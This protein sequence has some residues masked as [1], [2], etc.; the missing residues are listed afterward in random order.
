[1]EVPVAVPLRVPVPPQSPSQQQEEEM[2]ISAAAS[3]PNPNPV[4]DL[5]RDFSPTRST[6]PSSV[7]LG[8]HNRSSEEAAERPSRPEHRS[9]MSFDAGV[10]RARRGSF[11]FLGGRDEEEGDLGYSVLDGSDAAKKKVIAERLETVQT[12]NPVFTWC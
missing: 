8:V 7:R 11:G 5:L 6:L 2:D 10:T 9:V 12:R 1:M 4:P 3:A